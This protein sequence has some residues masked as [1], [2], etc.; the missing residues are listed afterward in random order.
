M[1]NIGKRLLTAGAATIVV[2]TLGAGVA[3][4]HNHSSGFTETTGGGCTKRGQHNQSDTIINATTTAVSGCSQVQVKVCRFVSGTGNV[5][6]T[7]TAATQAFKTHSNNGGL[8][9]L[10]YSDHNGLGSAW[11]GFR[12][13]DHAGS[14]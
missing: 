7:H 3:V 2:L 10:Y 8:D 5:L 11:F 4:A 14:C 12:L 13:S 9:H 1:S 6:S